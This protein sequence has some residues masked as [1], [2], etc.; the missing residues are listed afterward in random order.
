MSIKEKVEQLAQQAEAEKAAELRR[1]EEA[2]QQ[3]IAACKEQVRQHEALKADRLK[4]GKKI[5]EVIGVQRVFGEVLNILREEDP[6]VQL[7]IRKGYKYYSPGTISS[8]DRKYNRDLYRAFGPFDEKRQNARVDE[9]GTFVDTVAMVVEK[10]R[11]EG[12]ITTMLGVELNVGDP[13]KLWVISAFGLSD[14]EDLLRINDKD[15]FQKLENRLAQNIAQGL[16]RHFNHVPE[17]SGTSYG[18]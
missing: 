1:G 17:D 5:L 3:G 15:L 4:K 13:G 18:W 6:E 7:Q 12:E 9:M 14:Q 10:E 2:N 16:H 11:G 8:A